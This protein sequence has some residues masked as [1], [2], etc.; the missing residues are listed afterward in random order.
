MMNIYK[1]WML[2]H[3]KVYNGGI[4]ESEQRFKIFKDNLILID[5]HN[6]AEN[7]TYTVGLNE[8]SDLTDEEYRSY[9]LGLKF[10]A[11]HQFVLSK[12]ASQRYAASSA[13]ILP[14]SF[15]WRTKG[16]VSPIRKQGECGS[17]WAFSTI[18]A[19]EGINK[20]KTGELIDLSA[21][22]LIDC[23][24]TVNRGCKGG[25]VHQAFEF[26]T[27]NGGIDT[28][29]DYPY[30]EAD[31]TCDATKVNSKV[32]RI[33][34]YEFVP[35]NNENALMKAV[36]HQPISV[37]IEAGVWEFKN[38]VSGIYTGNCG[39]VLNHAVVVV[40][41]GSESGIDF[42]IVKN[43]W[44]KNWGEDGYV[45]IKRNDVAD[46]GKGKCGIVSFPS[47]PIKNENANVD[48][49]V[50]DVAGGVRR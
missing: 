31:G 25:F 10:D 27:R 1:K 26:I 8:L 43:S 5:D 46:I 22:E 39:T 49:D 11:S 23:D 35:S 2:E 14:E 3:E 42:W 41:Y 19:V 28:E 9:Y 29:E 48:V 33:D 20:I 24:R 37:Y 47:Y 50:D 4:E 38:Y 12:L 21:Q 44:G 17:C 7:R 45:R 13:E 40:G 6:A 30:Q 34:G 18:A 36:V 16:A 32:V 15:D